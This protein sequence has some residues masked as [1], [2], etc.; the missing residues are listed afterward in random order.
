[1]RDECWVIVDTETT[2]L[3]PPISAVEI[4][5]QR[6]K[7]W[8]RDGAPFRV[9]LN[10]DVLIEPAAEAVHGYSRHHLRQHGIQPR[11]AHALFREYAGELPLV[12][13][14]LSYDWDR[15]LLPEYGHLGVPP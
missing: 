12:A 10:H 11:T 13:H 2:G 1:M 7:G 14:N 15:V 6:M 8:E 9:L 5:A 3:Y 4:A